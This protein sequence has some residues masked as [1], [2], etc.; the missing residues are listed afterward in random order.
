MYDPNNF[1]YGSELEY[2]NFDIRR[3]L[4]AGSLN[5]KDVSV[6]SSTGI[7]ND[8]KGELYNFGGEINLD[9]SN[10]IEE[11]VNQFSE[12]INNLRPAPVC[13]Y[14]SNLHIHV[15]VPGLK[16]DLRML[17]QVLWY[18]N[19]Y[20]LEVFN[21]VEEI[22][23]VRAPKGT[24][25]YKWELKRR[26]RRFVSHQY[27]LPYKRVEAIMKAETPQEFF[28]EHAPLTEKGRMWYFSPRA[29]IN[30]RQLWEPSETIEFRH[31]P[32]TLNPIEFESC[33]RWCKH[34]MNMALNNPEENPTAVKE[35]FKF[36][37]FQPYEYETEQ[38]Y[39]WTNFEKNSRKTVAN[40][41]KEL[42]KRVDIDDMSI[43]SKEVY[44]VMKALQ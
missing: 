30:L 44:N 34:F 20:Q 21:Y 35:L 38:L 40:R 43:P 37:K 1:T 13:N 39:Q 17:K 27:C 3:P 24:D 6:V 4:V 33:V 15:R 16:N 26:K 14:R 12:I 19:E 41:L 31:F 8:P 9:P 32:G 22:P 7:A 23:D 5:D 28:E 18:I 36:P 11:H 2:G 29:G 25:E 42:R 10:T